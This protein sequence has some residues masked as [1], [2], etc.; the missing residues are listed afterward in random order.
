MNLEITLCCS[1]VITLIT[2]ILDTLMFRPN[3]SLKMTLVCSLIITMMTRILEV[4]RD[5]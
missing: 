4:V 2:W 5:Y 3:M 1:F